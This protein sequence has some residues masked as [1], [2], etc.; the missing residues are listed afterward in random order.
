M[1]TGEWMNCALTFF[2]YVFIFNKSKCII[3]WLF[4]GLSLSFFSCKS[5]V[6]FVIVFMIDFF[7]VVFR[8]GLYLRSSSLLS[9]FNGLCGCVHCWFSCCC[10]R[11]H[12]KKSLHT[13]QF[14]IQAIAL[15]EWKP[16]KIKNFTVDKLQQEMLLYTFGHVM[17]TGFEQK[18]IFHTQTDRHFDL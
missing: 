6:V 11:Y 5:L 10:S 17:S 4:S 18:S 9:F 15:T 8:T 14:R 1:H 13:V 2:L 12:H 3:F 16:P 7:V